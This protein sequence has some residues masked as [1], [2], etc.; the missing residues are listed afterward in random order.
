MMKCMMLAA[1]FGG[2]VA[3]ALP[4]TGNQATDQQDKPTYE[5]LEARLAELEAKYEQLAQDDWLTEARGVE[6]RALVQDVLADADTRASLLNSGM[7]AG[8]DN[9]FQISDT[10]GNFLL[11]INGQLQARWLWSHQREL[12]HQIGIPADEA[13][14]GGLFVGTTDDGVLDDAIADGLP[15][16]RGDTNRSGFENTRTKLWFSGHVVNPSWMY[17][18]EADFGRNGHFDLLDAWIAHYN[19]ETNWVAAIGQFKL[20]F[21]REELVDS[22]YQQAIER[23]LINSIFSV[24][25]SQG[26]MI[27]NQQEAFRF[28][29]AF[30]DGMRQANTGA[31]D[32]TTEFALTGRF[33]FLAAGAWEQFNEFRSAPGEQ[34]GV[35]IGVAGHWE[36]GEFGTDEEVSE[37]ISGTADLTAKFDSFNIF[38]AAIWNHIDFRGAGNTQSWAWVVQGG[39]HLTDD[40]EIFARYERTHWDSDALVDDISIITGGINHYI[41]NAGHAAKWSF[42]FGYAFN[43][44]HL[45]DPR[46]GWRADDLDDGA[47]GQFLVRTQFQLAF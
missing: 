17:L 43:P 30:S 1:T 21:L 41:F 34:T 16:S 4:A 5:Q 6:L 36:R 25:R 19:S 47:D 12:V 33:D 7:Q 15:T 24:G 35:M 20:P 37:L 23:S 10:S 11:Q 40:V 2:A 42:D 13:L 18:I 29:G 44:V 31:L 32:R 46:T 38:A 8:Y 3:L 22:R 27:S 14:L 39:Y 26:V 45:S 9:G 28:F